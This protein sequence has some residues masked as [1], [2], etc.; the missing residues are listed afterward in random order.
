MTSQLQML[1]IV[2]NKFFANSLRSYRVSDYIVE[3]TK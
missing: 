1:E 3:F 2:E